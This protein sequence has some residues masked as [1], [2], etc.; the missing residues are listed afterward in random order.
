MDEDQDYGLLSAL[1]EL[2]SLLVIVRF[3]GLEVCGLR[4]GVRGFG[5]W[6]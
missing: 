6:V 4:C 5:F 1:C 2:G 3:K